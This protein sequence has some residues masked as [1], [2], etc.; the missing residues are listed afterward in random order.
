MKKLLLLFVSTTF[1]FSILSAQYSLSG[2]IVDDTGT[3][4]EFANVLLHASADS[5]FVKGA[6]TE[7]DGSFTFDAVTAGSYYIQASQ[8]GLQ[9]QTYS[10]ILISSTDVALEPIT[11]TAGLALE[12][13][14]VTTTRPLIELKADKVIV[15][16]EGSSV[17]VGNNALEVLERSPGVTV[18]QDNNISLKGKQGVLITIDGKN[19]YIS[20]EQL[21]RMLES[22]PADAIASIEII[23]NPSAKYDAAG[24]AGVINIKLK[25]K[26]N[27]GTNGSLTLGAGHGRYA[28]ANSGINLNHRTEQMNL[29][30]SYNNRYWKGFQDININRSVPTATGL[31][32]FENQS[33][34]INISRSH[35]AKVGL[36]YY[37]SDRTTFGV[38]GRTNFG[39]FN[40]TNDN[41]TQ[42]AGVNQQNFDKSRTLLESEETWTQIAANINLAHE[43][44]D[45]SSINV[46]VDYSIYDNPNHAMYDNFFYLSDGSQAMADLLL[47]NTSDVNVD[48]LATKLDYNTQIGDISIETGAKYSYVTTD[49]NTEFMEYQNTEW[50]SDPTLSNEFTYDESIIAGYLNGST[51]IG[52]VNLQAGLRMEH[53]ISDG[54][55]PTM[56]QQVKK[57]YTNLF[58]SMSISHPIGEKSN[59]SYTYS[60]RI[61]RPTY[62][63]LNPFIYFLD[64]FTFMKGNPFLSPQMS[65]AFGVNYSLGRSLFVSANYSHTTDAMTEILDQNDETQQTFQTVVNLD[66]FRNYSL[67]VTAP[68]VVGQNWTTRW[69]LT[70]FYNDFSSANSEIDVQSDQLSYH[71]NVSNDIS[72]NDK[73][74]AEVGAFYQSALTYGIFEIKP[75]YSVDLGASYKV[76]EG[77][78]SLKLS[79]KDIFWTNNNDVLIDHESIDLRTRNVRESRRAQLTF[80]YNFGNQKVKKARNR[81]TAMSDEENRVGRSN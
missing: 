54:Y 35:N 71:I 36:D 79:V 13:V 68:I 26:E 22:M 57:E 60:R 9:T 21:S 65:N 52:K 41:I 30:G 28:K 76:M 46:D 64:Q 70:G 80:N 16:V 66:D 8:V 23:Q 2:K 20:N 63:N 72:I 33:D 62:R 48:I 61:D 43:I 11:L 24:N 67:N 81:S 25:K 74:K 77:K 73:L 55:S 4:L 53:T 6:I 42:I 14:V 50:V 45:Q 51:I 1:C 3:G 31:S 34:M 56:D 39:R 7:L 18:D 32:F 40:G 38:L 44:S 5:S 75:R 69:S 15:N 47:D 58:P 59:L 10:D 17:S 19:Q 27:L 78:G 49:N 37:L 29:Y 12:E